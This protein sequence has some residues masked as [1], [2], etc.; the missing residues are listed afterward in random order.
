MSDVGAIATDARAA[1]HLHRSDPL[2]PP[3]KRKRRRE[4]AQARARKPPQDAAGSSEFGSTTDRD[5]ATINPLGN[6]ALH[7]DPAAT[8]PRAGHSSQPSRVERL[9]KMRGHARANFRRAASPSGP[10]RVEMVTVTRRSASETSTADSTSMP[11]R[12]MTMADEEQQP[13]AQQPVA[14][15]PAR[16]WLFGAG[17]VIV[18]VVISVSVSASGT[19]GSFAALNCVRFGAASSAACLHFAALFLVAI[20]FQPVGGEGAAA[21]GARHRSIFS[22]LALA[23]ACAVAIAAPSMG[24]PRDACTTKK[25]STLCDCGACSVYKVDNVGN[26]TQQNKTECAAV[27]FGTTKETED[28]EDGRTC[29]RGNAAFELP[30]QCSGN[31][32]RSAKAMISPHMSTSQAILDLVFRFVDTSRSARFGEV[33]THE[34]FD[35][36]CSEKDFPAC[37]ADSDDSAD[38]AAM[39]EWA[40]SVFVAESAKHSVCDGIYRHCDAADQPRAACP[41]DVCCS[42]CNAAR[43]FF[44][45]AHK[46]QLSEKILRDIILKKTQTELKPDKIK[47][48]LSIVSEDPKFL[49]TVST[50]LNWP[51]AFLLDA[52]RAKQDWGDCVETCMARPDLPEWYGSHQNC[53]SNKDRHR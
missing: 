31:S 53:L 24:G 47:T 16:D 44:E 37:P 49:E 5:R 23:L 50:A 42:I 11:V 17:I 4:Q 15:R 2:P 32:S 12:P 40:A 34:P 45:C 36:K 8:V 10:A 41:D 46:G 13:V 33:S 19:D 43:A 51:V 1:R 21:S 38:S 30:R 22:K 14:A 27:E 26:E 29:P 52:T 9:A 25:N 7:N 28:V 20:A 3:A 6:P 48:E 35:Q 39:G 18:T